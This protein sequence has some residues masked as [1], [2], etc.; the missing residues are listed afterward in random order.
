MKSDG[1][2]RPGQG[3]GVEGPRKEPLGGDPGWEP[4]VLG[5]QMEE[6]A[7]SVLDRQ[8]IIPP[9]EDKWPDGRGKARAAVSTGKIH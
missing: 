3:V 9:G 7:A 4:A 1:S 2:I 6:Q 8:R 5:A